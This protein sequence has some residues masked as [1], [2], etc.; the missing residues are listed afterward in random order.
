MWDSYI[1][2]QETSLSEILR[3]TS[4][5][6]TSETAVGGLL[7]LAIKGSNGNPIEN[8]LVLKKK[9]QNL[10]SWTKFR[11]SPNNMCFSL[12]LILVVLMCFIF[13]NIRVI[14]L[15]DSSAPPYVP[16]VSPF[17]LD[18]GGSASKGG[19]KKAVSTSQNHQ[20]T[21]TKNNE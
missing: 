16:A 4:A 20:T 2:Y 11:G 12:L 9:R 5:S 18:F 17:S 3:P 10:P 15:I 1:P 8:M 21:Q 6:F 19:N 7:T 14:E 13:R